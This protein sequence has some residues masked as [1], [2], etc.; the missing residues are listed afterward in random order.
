MI[1]NAIDKTLVSI[2]R[3]DCLHNEVDSEVD[4]VA[5]QGSSAHNM[6]DFDDCYPLKVE[7]AVTLA[8]LT[9]IIMVHMHS[10]VHVNVALNS[11][12]SSY[13]V[14]TYMY[15]ETSWHICVYACYWALLCIIIWIW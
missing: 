2:D 14:V 11:T 10:H 4:S 5:M 9:G 8:F 12:R 1:G 6:T 3:S 15:V 13:C 7:M